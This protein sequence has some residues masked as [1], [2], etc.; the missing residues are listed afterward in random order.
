MPE[1][2]KLQMNV[3]DVHKSLEKATIGRLFNHF[4]DTQICFTKRNRSYNLPFSFEKKVI[5][6][7]DIILV[8]MLLQYALCCSVVTSS[9]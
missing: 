4:Y 9:S 1:F 7:K 5:L 2:F 6:R 8:F 3:A